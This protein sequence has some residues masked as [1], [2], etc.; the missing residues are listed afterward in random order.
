MK[1]TIRDLD[2]VVRRINLITDSPQQAYIEIASGEFK[3]QVGNYHL[4]SAYGGYCLHRINNES[5]GI[6]TPINSGYV[7][8]RELYSLMQAYIRGLQD[9]GIENDRVVSSGTA[10]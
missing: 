3:A 10:N 8:K 6:T 5:G 4:S 2:A 1:I 7:S 9:T